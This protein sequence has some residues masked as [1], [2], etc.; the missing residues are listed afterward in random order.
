MSGF[1]YRIAL[2]ATAAGLLASAPLA[3]AS[4]P[5][6]GVTVIADRT[7]TGHD[8]TGIA[9]SGIDR[10]QLWALVSHK[11][12]DLKTPAGAAEF[13]RR[14]SS[15]AQTLCRQLQTLYP[16]GSPDAETCARYT[17]KAADREVKAAE[18]RKTRS[19]FSS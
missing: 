1:P 13:E 7:V 2:A 5:V 17:A 12:L 15:A 4:G 9:P 3:R 14:V 11:D 16:S 18:G 10:V 6:G 8:P 19:P